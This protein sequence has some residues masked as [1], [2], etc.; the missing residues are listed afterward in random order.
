MTASD[1]GFEGV[2]A[3]S[4]QLLGGAHATVIATVAWAVLCLLDAQR[5]T[6]AALARALPAERAGSGRSCLRR[7]RRWWAG[8]A[9][10]D[11]PSDAR[12]TL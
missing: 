4:K 3:W 12:H 8:A 6:P 10:R 2:H 5:A 9:S 1:E 11:A 7:G